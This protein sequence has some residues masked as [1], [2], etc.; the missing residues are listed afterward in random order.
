VVPG[1]NHRFAEPT[2]DVI[3]GLNTL[4]L[5]VAPPI[6]F[7]WFPRICS[8]VTTVGV[9]FTFAFQDPELEAAAIP[10]D[11]NVEKDPRSPPSDT[12]R[13]AAERIAIGIFKP[14]R[15]RI[16]PLPRFIEP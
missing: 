15:W 6:E 16:R 12:R 3:P 13:S 7:G 9:Q 5:C 2:G 10:F 14:L 8:I 4:P 1:V 11:A